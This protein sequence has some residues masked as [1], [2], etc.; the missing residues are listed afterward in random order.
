MKTMPKLKEIRKRYIKLSQLHHPDRI[1][2][3]KE[4]TAKFQ[5]IIN[6]YHT[7]GK[8]CEDIIYEDEDHDDTGK[9]NVQTHCGLTSWKPCLDSPKT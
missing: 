4:S 8:A 6:A 5:S 2:G 1:C 9:K 3:S 7:A